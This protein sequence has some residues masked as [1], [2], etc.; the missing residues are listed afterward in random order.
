MGDVRGFLKHK[1]ETMQYRPV[2]ERVADYA[3]VF[4]LKSDEKAREQAA[5]CMD[6]GTPFCHSG[7]P[8]G[9]IIP[10][11]NDL[12][13]KGFWN[14]AFDLLS[15][16]NN[17]PEITGRVCPAPCEYACVLGI[18]DDPVTIRE[19]EL[20]IIEKA[21]NLGYVK[22]TP[23]K[24]RTG[25]SVAIV[26]SGPA[27]LSCAAQLNRLG[28]N[29]VVFE[30]EEKLGGLM[31]YGIPDFKL[32]KKVLDRRI[33]IWKKEGIEFKTEVNVGLDYSADKLLKEFDA[34]CLTGGSKA[35]RDLNIPGRE[36]KG[37]HFAMDYLVQANKKVSGE[38]F[39]EPKISATGKKVLVIGGGDTGSDCVGTANRQ[40]ASCV[41]Q[42]EVLPEP[43]A[44]RDNK[45]PWPAYPL[46]LKTTS[47]HEEGVTRKWSILTKKFIGENGVV[48]KVACVEVDFSGKDSNGRF[49][50]K[51]IP[52]SEFE[53]ETD[54][55]LL[56]IGFLHPEH[57]GLVSG[58]K[59]ELDP[60]GNVKTDDNYMTSAKKV[61]SAGDMHRGQSLVVWAIME[62][63]MAAVGI[64]RFLGM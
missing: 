10:E 46:L 52:G 59:V 18:N 8:L 61:F 29:V 40:G 4:N 63:R 15:A 21:F 25:K 17:L 49:V 19:D 54:L 39:A 47:S 51:E 55:V 6:C 27:G 30:R 60:R 58:L 12:M 53:I 2:C 35:P 22:A 43:P 28:H 56:A 38:K 50:M 16:T 62:G 32:D 3:E 20:S 44:C 37:I 36:L 26:G 64:D 41:I 31:R 57:E 24:Q 33:D 9:N 45:C 5:R 23:P 13:Y 34:V 7:C 14:K 1:R 48:K 42:I 11:W